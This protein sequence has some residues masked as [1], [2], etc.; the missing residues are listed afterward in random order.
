VGLGHR[1]R[2]VGG[3]PPRAPCGK[4]QPFDSWIGRPQR[5]PAPKRPVVVGL[6][7]SVYEI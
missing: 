6:L 3:F 4:R 5:A 1:I 2:R 7:L